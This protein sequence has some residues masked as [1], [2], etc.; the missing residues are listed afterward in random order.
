MNFLIEWNARLS[1][2]G[3]ALRQELLRDPVVTL[4]DLRPEDVAR[5][6]TEKGGAALGHQGARTIGG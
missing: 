6:R 5:A 4:I 1:R 2:L 3:Y